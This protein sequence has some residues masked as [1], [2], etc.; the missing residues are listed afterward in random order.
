MRAVHAI[1]R[2]VL[3]LAAVLVPAGALF[4]TM[5]YTGST[6]V[7][8][9]LPYAAVLLFVLAIV[10]AFAWACVR[11]GEFPPKL[12]IALTTFPFL[13]LTLLMMGITF[14]AKTVLPLLFWAVQLA[15]AIV[16]ARKATRLARQ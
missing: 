10:G 6:S 9:L 11:W 7:E 14:A 16:V 8:G 4:V 1:G 15:L 13:L 2:C 5:G 12:A 3:G